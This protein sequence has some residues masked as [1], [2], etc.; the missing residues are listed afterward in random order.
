MTVRA[1]EEYGDTTEKM[2]GRGD[3][4]HL[5]SNRTGKPDP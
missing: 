1:M 3:D 5:P 2:S 4:N